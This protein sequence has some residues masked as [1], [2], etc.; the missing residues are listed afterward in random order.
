MIKQWQ[1]IMVGPSTSIRETIGK[2]DA[3]SLQFALVADDQH[4]LLG[5]VTD[6]DVRR[7]ILKGMA[8]DEPV[9]QIMNPHPAFV[10]EGESRE[11][12]FSIMKEKQ[13]HH[14]P[15]LDGEGRVVGLEL[16]DHLLHTPMRDNW[17]VLMAGGLGTRLGP[18]TKDCP[19]PLLKVGNKPILERILE[20]F[21][22]YRFS[23]FCI[24]VNYMADSIKDCFGDGSRWGVEI[25]YIEEDQKLGT[26]GALGLLPVKTEAPLV[27]MNG[28]L[29]TRVNLN[30]LLDFHARHKAQATMCVR[31]Y[32]FQVPYGVVRI[33][34][35]R[36]TGIDEKPLHRF[37][38]NA[39]IY[40]LE[41]DV[42]RLVA[43]NIACDM[44]TLFEKLMR[45]GY[46]TAA[47]PIREYWLDVGQMDDFQRANWE[48]TEALHD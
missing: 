26:A 1:A 32:S 34:D 12:A 25:Q 47:F 30:H 39:G 33:D 6:G 31:E 5:T 44:T 41:P 48:F 14:V 40:I 23:R 42:V 21:I 18:L 8:L 20:N 19:K 46:S 3:G 9:A 7:G 28:D 10:R 22:A 29:L 2:I 43:R 16:V 4:R 36:L 35:Y 17:V 24:S 15:V 13:I 11:R 45:E 27:I 37:F 38:V